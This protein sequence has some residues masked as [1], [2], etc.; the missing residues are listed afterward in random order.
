MQLA[1]MPHT[2]KSL[3]ALCSASAPRKAY[4]WW[5][6]L[7]YH[8]KAR[9]WSVLFSM[10]QNILQEKPLSIICIYNIYMCVH[11]ME[12]EEMGILSHRHSDTFVLRIQRS[13]PLSKG[14]VQNSIQYLVYH[15]QNFT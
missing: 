13:I 3:V 14:I 12:Q 10:I 5:F 8:P 6:S 4:L 15:I 9:I 7:P 2:S 1:C 11:V